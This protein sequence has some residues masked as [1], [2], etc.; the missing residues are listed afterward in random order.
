MLNTYPLRVTRHTP[1][2][3]GLDG[4]QQVE[5]FSVDIEFD[6]VPVLSGLS[7]SSNALIA[8]ETEEVVFTLPYEDQG[9]NLARIFGT[10]VL[11]ANNIPF[12][13]PVSGSE[14]ITGF[15]ADQ[16]SGTF[17]TQVTVHC[18]EADSNPVTFT[19][20]LLDEFDQESEQRTANLTVDY[21][22]CE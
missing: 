8:D 12:D 21:S 10:V 20:Q 4:P 14:D 1:N 9:A 2:C 11:A 5:L 13:N 15:D 17:E 22:E 3:P 18:S 7:A 19:I 16:G 6:P